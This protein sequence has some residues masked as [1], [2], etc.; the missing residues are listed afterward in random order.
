[1]TEEDFFIYERETEVKA[2]ILAN[3]GKKLLHRVIRVVRRQRNAK[4]E[5]VEVIDCEEDVVLQP[6]L[7]DAP[8]KH[9][10]QTR[11]RKA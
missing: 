5:A 6:G 9:F 1:M 10:D 11:R 3:L 8:K 4:T 2:R 7:A